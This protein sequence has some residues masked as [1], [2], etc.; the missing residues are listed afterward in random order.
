MISAAARSSCIVVRSREASSRSSSIA[1]ELGIVLQQ[2]H[3]SASRPRLQRR[4]FA[5]GLV[6]NRLEL[7]HCLRTI[8]AGDRND[9]R[10]STRRNLAVAD[11]LPSIHAGNSHCRQSSDPEPTRLAR[12][13]FVQ[14]SQFGRH[15]DLSLAQHCSECAGGR[16]R[17]EAPVAYQGRAQGRERLFEPGKSCSALRAM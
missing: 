3:G 7:E 9:Q 4:R 16:W 11:Q 12:V 14:L 1:P 5:A 6:V 17:F 8:A 15:D 10:D 13:F 2:P